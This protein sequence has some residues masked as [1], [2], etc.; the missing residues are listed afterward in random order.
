MTAQTIAVV[1]T[2]RPATREDLPFIAWCNYESSSPYPGFC[3]WD[4]L[5]EGFNTPTMTFIHALFEADA[6]AYGKVEDFFILEEAGKP[7]GGAS[8]FVMSAEDFRPLHL[9]R[10]ADVAHRL[11]WSPATLETFLTRYQSVWR[12]PQDVTIAA[13][14]P[15]TIE[16]VAVIPEARG[17]GIGRQLLGAIIQ[18]GKAHGHSHVGIA[19]TIGNEPA[20]KLYEGLGFKPYVTYWAAYFEE[21]FPGTAKYRMALT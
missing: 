7:L 3:Y 11:G 20:Q 2:V 15:W 6:L 13:S 12:D 14:A 19:V 21:Q 18:A 1:R 16:C 9:H 5:L 10:M 8:G 17:R 4:P